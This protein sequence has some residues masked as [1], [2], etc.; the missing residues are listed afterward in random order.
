M[1]WIVI[2]SLKLHDNNCFRLSVENVGT[3]IGDVVGSVVILS[4]PSPLSPSS[5]PLL[6]LLRSFHCPPGPLEFANPHLASGPRSP[7][8]VDGRQHLALLRSLASSFSVVLWP[9]PLPFR[10]RDWLP[11][12]CTC[13]PP[14]WA[15]GCD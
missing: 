11:L 4:P 13:R 2:H 7:A 8:G 14:S 6:L 5:F 3:S 1:V 9:L 15:V 10:T 12:R